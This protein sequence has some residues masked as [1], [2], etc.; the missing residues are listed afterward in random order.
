MNMYMCVCVCTCCFIIF[1]SYH[2]YFFFSLNKRGTLSGDC[3]WKIPTTVMG[4]QLQP[5]LSKGQNMA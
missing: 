1:C 4:H 3:V 5:H 2:C